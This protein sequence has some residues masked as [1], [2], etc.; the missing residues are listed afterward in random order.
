MVKHTQNKNHR[1]MNHVNPFVLNAPFLET[2]KTW[3]R[4]Q[5]KSAFGANGLNNV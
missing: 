3:G 4:G 2:L 1:N 5:R